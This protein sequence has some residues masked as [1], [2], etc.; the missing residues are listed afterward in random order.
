[1]FGKWPTVAEQEKAERERQAAQPPIGYDPIQQK[2]AEQ[3]RIQAHYDE[4]GVISPEQIREV[5][6]RVSRGDASVAMERYTSH[7]NPEP[8]TIFPPT[9]DDWRSGNGWITI[10]ANYTST[11]DALLSFE[12]MRFPANLSRQTRPTC[13]SIGGGCALVEFNAPQQFDQPETM[14]WN[15]PLIQYALSLGAVVRMKAPRRTVWAEYYLTRFGDYMIWSEEGERS[16]QYAKDK[17]WTDDTG[18]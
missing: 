3:I 18:G 8:E 17:D 16:I 2:V 4:P 13:L 5:Q 12:A 6:E 7:Q 9:M 15:E 10:Y 11:I 14:D 1:M